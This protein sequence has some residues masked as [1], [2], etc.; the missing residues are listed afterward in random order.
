M[1]KKLKGFKSFP[2]CS[3]GGTLVPYRVS[4]NTSEDDALVS[5]S[6]NWVCEK[7]GKRVDI[8]KKL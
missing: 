6:L 8:D 7:C 5:W 4:A 2:K 1:D 3:C